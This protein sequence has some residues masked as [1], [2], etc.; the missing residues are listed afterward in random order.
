M[1][2]ISLRLGMALLTFLVG[3]GTAWSYLHILQPMLNALQRPPVSE[4]S[5]PPAL[6]SSGSLS[7]A[8]KIS[9]TR[10]YRSEDGLINAEFEVVNLSGELLYY[11][12]YSKGD[13]QFWSV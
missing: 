8:V 2:R 12:G 7:E 9:L 5:I 3:V 6:A 13:N 10:S 4:N 1:K 11:R